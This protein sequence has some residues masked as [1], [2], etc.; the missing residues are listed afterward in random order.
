VGALII[1][2]RT[3]PLAVIEAKRFSIDPYAAKD[4]AR[5]YAVSLNAPFVIL[6][7]GQDHYFWD[8]ADGDARPILGMPT[9]ANL[10]RLIGQPA[11]WKN[12]PLPPTD[13]PVTFADTS[14]AHRRLGYSPRVSVEEGLTRFWDWFRQI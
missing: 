6:S 11:M 3:R 4:Q 2:S 5:E 10:E 14:K 1:F 12:A 8:Y 9:Q 7:N 13:L